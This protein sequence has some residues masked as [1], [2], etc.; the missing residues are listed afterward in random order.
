MRIDLHIHTKPL[1][2]DSTMDVEEAIQ[3]A[4]KIGVDG[5]CLTEHNRVWKAEVIKDLRKKWDF[6]LLRGIEVETFEGHIL[7]FGLFRDFESIIR[8]DE[9]RNLVDREEG[10]LAAA[11]PFKGFLVFGGSVK[12]GL[13]PEKASQRPVF[14]KVDLIEG[15]SGRLSESENT[16]AQE[17]G[18]MLGLKC[19]G[20]SDA[21]SLKNIGKCVT[22]F[23][24]KI[25]NEA[26]L[27]TEL[28]AGRFH[29][30]H[31]RT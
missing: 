18:K 9:L 28:K 10:M 22:I 29:A 2:P 16:L 7:A 24:K 11:H 26:D 31:F 14:R 8:L 6:L 15:F 19:T 13:T 25:D 21:H 1:S 5:L 20:G 30:A 23:E 4:K 27:V 12:L 17:V 3:E